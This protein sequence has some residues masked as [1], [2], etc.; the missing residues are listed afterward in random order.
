M[1]Y[2]Y[3]AA[4]KTLP[5]KRTGWTD[6][7]QCPNVTAAKL[8]SANSTPLLPHSLIHWLAHTNI[9]KENFVPSSSGPEQQ[10]PTTK[11]PLIKL[12]KRLPSAPSPS[13][14]KRL[15]TSWYISGGTPPYFLAKEL[16]RKI[17]DFYYPK[18]TYHINHTTKAIYTGQDHTPTGTSMDL[19]LQKAQRPVYGT[20]V[21]N[22]HRW[23][24][25][26][27]PSSSHP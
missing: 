16:T 23:M 14:Y 13:N 18:H 21:V 27:Q 5:W 20:T 10:P 12:L 3:T 17:S 26:N 7:K 2:V 1:V 8:T 15:K 25:Q 19:Q 9:L 4:I 6:S 22:R 11:A 24:P